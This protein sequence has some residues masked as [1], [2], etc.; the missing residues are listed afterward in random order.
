VPLAGLPESTLDLLRVGYITACVVHFSVTLIA[1][2][3][4]R[5][6]GRQHLWFGVE[7]L[8]NSLG[9]AFLLGSIA[10]A[11][12]VLTRGPVRIVSNKDRMEKATEI[13]DELERLTKASLYRVAGEAD[14][15]LEEIR[16]NLRN[17]KG[18]RHNPVATFQEYQT[19]RRTQSSP[20]YHYIVLYSP[21]NDTNGRMFTV[22]DFPLP[23]DI[24]N[25]VKRARTGASAWTAWT[26]VGHVAVAAY[27]GDDIGTLVVATV[28]DERSFLEA[29]R[30][31]W[32]KGEYGLSL[33]HEDG[34]GAPIVTYSTEIS[35][36]GERRIREVAEKLKPQRIN[37]VSH[38]GHVEYQYEREAQDKAMLPDLFFRIRFPD[39]PKP[40]IRQVSS[41]IFWVAVM[42]LVL[43]FLLWDEADEPSHTTN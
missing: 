18:N 28:W 26:E 42:L 6:S 24:E 15:R 9:V 17:A 10:T 30:P 21:N 36:Y 38:L 41:A 43:G 23:K 20:S 19:E 4:Q 31:L 5:L 32:D 2:V 37:E 25:L 33:I 16:E 40:T 13:T 12:V 22:P 27:N 11:S 8:P 3:I 35:D 14:G 34:S 7:R 29:T 39:T 1:P